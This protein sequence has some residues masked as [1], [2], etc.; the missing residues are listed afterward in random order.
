MQGIGWGKK[1]WGA[2]GGVLGVQ[3]KAEG[4]Q[5]GVRVL[6]ERLRKEVLA[7]QPALYQE[8]TALKA[9]EATMQVCLPKDPH[10]LLFQSLLLVSSLLAIAKLLDQLQLCF[11]FC[12]ICFHFLRL[13]KSSGKKGPTTC[14]RHDNWG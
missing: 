8:V 11:L 14:G 7:R 1:G 12:V 9:A 10:S 13:R 3:A 4:V 6:T 2:N 5:E